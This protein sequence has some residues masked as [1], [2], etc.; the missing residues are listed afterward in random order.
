MQFLYIAG[1]IK[2]GVGLIL[3]KTHII[4]ENNY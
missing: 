4:N 1:I 2:Y 3:R